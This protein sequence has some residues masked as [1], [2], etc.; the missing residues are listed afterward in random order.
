[1]TLGWVFVGAGSAGLGVGAALGVLA[2]AEASDAHCVADKCDHGTVGGIK[3]AA[4]GSDIGW[5][6]G[7]VLLA[8]GATLVLTAPRP[9]RAPSL[10]LQVAPAVAPGRGEIIV[11]GSW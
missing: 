4:L 8:G 2:L 6:A 10:A 5:I 11:G 9:S 1:L 7:G 3:A